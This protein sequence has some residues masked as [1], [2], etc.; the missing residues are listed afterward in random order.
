MSYKMGNPNLLSG[1]QI[2]SASTAYE[3]CRL[4]LGVKPQTG[5]RVTL[6]IKFTEPLSA[7]PTIH[8]YYTDASHRIYAQNDSGLDY[9]TFTFSWAE[10]GNNDRLRLYG[11]PQNQT[12]IV[13][14][15]AKL[16]YGEEATPF[17]GYAE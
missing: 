6:Q 8:I 9:I 10:Y 13:I 16:E 2:P 7:R 5:D 15:W 3:F 11:L 4:L 17:D 14:A 1:L 12:P